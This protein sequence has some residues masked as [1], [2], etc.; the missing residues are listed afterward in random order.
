MN[1]APSP[2]HLTLR[3]EL[4]E[5]FEREA[6]TERIAALDRAEVFPAEIYAAMAE[7]GLCGITIDPRDGG[8]GFDEIAICIVVEELA[9][10]CGS[11]VSAF[12]PTVTFCAKGIARH[13]TPDQ[14]REYLPEIA[15]GRLRMAMALSEPDAGSD[16][17]NLSTR[18][19]ERGDEWLVNGRKAWV[20]GADSSGFIL[21]FVRTDPST[22]GAR[23]L[24]VLLIPS[25]A[26][27][28][29]V[30]P[31]QKL[32]GQ[33]TRTCDVT[34]DDVRVPAAN[35]L[36]VVDGGGGLIFDL[37]DAERIGVAAQGCGVAQGA[38]DLALR[39][40]EQR[41]Q[42]GHPIVE[43]QAVGHPL[44]DIAIGIEMARLLTWRAAWKLEHGLP[45]SMDAS[46]AKVAGSEIGTR[47]ANRGM[48][49]LGGTSYLV[50][51]GMERYWRES[52]LYEIGG[53]ANEIQRGIILK[54]PRQQQSETESMG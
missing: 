3:R 25:D 16:L 52:K 29:H 12:V 5:F 8:T 9:R 21:A 13:G 47:A 30:R 53:G 38:L 17:T 48:Q 6:P 14:K 39:Y 7:M 10:A 36:G 45:C 40:A 4:R 42:F 37:L 22:R 32:A 44:A 20:S 23:G 27:G 24:S 18:A 31:L 46:M 51:A 26:A 2:E 15:A 50:D 1:F 19:V 11:L 35:L 49:T 54:H 41:V 33:A 28:V 43:F 34:F